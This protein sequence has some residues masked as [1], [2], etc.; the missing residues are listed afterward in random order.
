MLARCRWV[1]TFIIVGILAGLATQ[2]TGY[3]VPP[4]VLSAILSPSGAG[5]LSTISPS[6]GHSAWIGYQILYGFGIGSGFQTSTLPAQYVLP[7]ADVPLGMALTFF[8]Q[9][10]GGTVFLA[11]SQNIFASILVKSLSGVAGLNAA[12]IVNT[13]AT[14]L[15]TVVTAN[16]FKTVINAYSHAVTRVYLLT[17]VVSACMVL[18]ALCVEWKRVPRKN[19]GKSSPNSSDTELG[20]SESKGKVGG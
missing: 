6:S 17:A 9:Q 11:V 12:T 4:M 14:D 10:L 16:H 1:I 19:D 5:M 18:G 20:E 8:M 15:R 13:G 2:K 3:Y 7:R